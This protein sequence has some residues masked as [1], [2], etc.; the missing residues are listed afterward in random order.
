MYPA[1]PTQGIGGTG[2]DAVALGA[3]EAD[4]DG[5]RVGPFG[6]QGDAGPLWVVLSEVLPRAD[7]RADLTFRT[8]RRGEPEHG[9]TP[10]ENR[11]LGVI[12]SEF[13][14]SVRIWNE[15]LP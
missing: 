1:V 11:E 4:P 12:H 14:L 5:W 9:E 3:C 2:L 8:L 15:A 10:P 13:G 7:L 6:F